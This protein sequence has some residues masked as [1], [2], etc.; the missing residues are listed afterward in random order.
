MSSPAAAETRS[1]AIGTATGATIGAQ[2]GAPLD[3][4]RTGATEHRGASNDVIPFRD[5]PYTFANLEHNAGGLMAEHRWQRC[6]N[7]AVYGV[8]I[9]VAHATGLGLDK[10]LIRAGIGDIPH[11]RYIAA[12]AVHALLRL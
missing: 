1:G 7:A 3:A 8:E 11:L 2:V 4:L 6:A 12:C 5:I 10:H 9:T